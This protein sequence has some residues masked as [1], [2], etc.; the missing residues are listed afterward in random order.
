MS[1]GK[2]RHGPRREQQNATNV[3]EPVVNHDNR[4]QLVK[5]L[6]KLQ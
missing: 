3:Y 4:L 2:I 6:R 5:M 1:G